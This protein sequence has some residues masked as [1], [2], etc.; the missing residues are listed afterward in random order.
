M[1]A[2]K[3]KSRGELIRELERLRDENKKS[4]EYLTFLENLEAIDRVL[5]RSTNLE[6]MMKEVLETVLWVF[7]CDRAYLLYPCDPEA[8]SWKVPMECTRPEYPGVMSIGVEIP[9]ESYAKDIIHSALDSIDPVRYDPGSI[10]P[11]PP[12]LFKQFGIQSQVVTAIYPFIG[13]PWLFGLHQ[14]SYPRTWLPQELKLITEISSRLSAGLSNLLLFR[15][16]QESEEKLKNIFNAAENIA[17]ILTNVN[18]INSKIIEFSPGAEIIFGFKKSE[19]INQPITQ[20]YHPSENN[21]LL[22]IQNKLQQEKKGFSTQ[23]TL[24]RKS[25]QLFSATVTISP[26]YNSTHQLTSILQVAIEMV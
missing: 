8:P 20:L 24:V 25:G 6:H 3:K 14:C 11:L 13:K 26:L 23:R 19:I 2:K 5:G 9:M 4:R 17:F 12:N 21:F 22:E 10:L 7:G 1:S 15:D 16:I 18:G